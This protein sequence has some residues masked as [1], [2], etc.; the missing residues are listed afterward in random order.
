VKVLACLKSED[1]QQFRSKDSGLLTG[2]G[3]G[4]QEGRKVKTE[5]GKEH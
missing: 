4:F 1:R 3:F 5:K 2:K